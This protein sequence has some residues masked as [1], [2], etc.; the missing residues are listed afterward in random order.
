MR[1]LIRL[2]VSFSAEQ[3]LSSGN[4][5]PT[6]AKTGGGVNQGRAS[7]TRLNPPRT[8]GRSLADEATEA[9]EPGL[10]AGL[11]YSCYN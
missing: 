1:F 7:S 3:Q 11:C 9:D 5:G 2:P 10:P 6:E 4:Q 8:Y